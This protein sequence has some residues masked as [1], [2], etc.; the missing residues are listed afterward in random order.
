MRVSEIGINPCVTQKH[1]HSQNGN[2]AGDLICG[3]LIYRDAKPPTPLRE[4]EPERHA[5]IN[6]D[7]TVHCDSL[8]VLIWLFF[9]LYVYV[10]STV[11]LLY[12]PIAC[13]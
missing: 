12:N 7:L 2:T 11:C 4:L 8:V 13:F 3:T 6:A 9:V 5:E 1:K 10:Q